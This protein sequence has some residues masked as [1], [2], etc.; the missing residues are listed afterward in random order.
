MANRNLSTFFP[1]ES[2]FG[3]SIL[4]IYFD[5]LLGLYTNTATRLSSHSYIPF[6]VL[7]WKG[8]FKWCRQKGE[9]YLISFP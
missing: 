3:I 9:T 2:L 8:D 1:S 6:T 5:K 4:G 7:D